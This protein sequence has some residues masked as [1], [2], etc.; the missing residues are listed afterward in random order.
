MVR[1]GNIPYLLIEDRAVDKSFSYLSNDLVINTVVRK[2]EKARS[3]KPSS[4]VTEYTLTPS[5][6]SLIK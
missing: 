4:M 6:F 5:L 2:L 1:L 3:G